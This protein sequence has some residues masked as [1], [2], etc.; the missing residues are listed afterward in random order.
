MS[1]THAVSGA[2]T[3]NW[4]ARTLGATRFS[5]RRRTTGYDGQVAEHPAAPPT[6]TSGPGHVTARRTSHWIRDELT[7]RADI[8]RA[9]AALL[10]P[11]RAPLDRGAVLEHIE[12][13]AATLHSLGIGAGHR[14]ATIL[15]P[16]PEAAL[17]VLGVA[18]VSA[19]A[20]LDPR[21]PPPEVARMLADVRT[22]AVILPAGA[23]REPARAQGCAVI[24]LEARPSRGAG[25]HAL[26]VRERGTP[27][28]PAPGEAALLLRTSGTT[29]RPKWVALR[30]D[31]LVASARH[32]EAAL[33][34]SRDDRCLNLMPLFHINGLVMTLAT[35]LTGGSIAC[36]PGF[37]ADRFAG[38]LAALTPTWING[39]PTMLRAMARLARGAP[40][41]GAERLR[42]IR[43][44]SAPLAPALMAE[45]EH[46]FGVPVIETY[47]HTETATLVTANPLS[48]GRR[49]PGSVGV[50][51]A[52][53]AMVVDDAGAPVPAGTIGEVVV[54]GPNVI[55][56]YEDDADAAAFRDGWLRTGDLGR[57]DEDGYLFL[58]GR[59]K[60]MINRGG[61]KIAPREVDEA[62]AGHPAVAAAA[63]FPVPH[64]TLGED[65]AAA[66]VLVP[67]AH[68]SPDELQAFVATQLA[69]FK[70]PRRVAVVDRLPQG[71]TGKVDRA[72][73][74]RHA[75]AAPERSRVP[76]RTAQ[77][78]AVAAI[79]CEALGLGAVGVDEDFFTLGGDSILA[80]QV[81]ARIH[82][83]TG[84]ELPSHALFEAPTVARLSGLLEG[85][86]AADR[87]RPEPRLRARELAEA[88]LSFAQEGLWFLDQLHPGRTD[89]NVAQAWRLRGPLDTSALGRSLQ[90]VV[91]R[92][93]ALRTV[94]LAR[95]GRPVQR[96]LP[97]LRLELPVIDLTGRAADRRLDEARR[98]ARAQAREPFALDRGPLVRGALLRMDDADHVLILTIHHIVFD[99][100]SRGVLCRELSAAYAALVAGRDPG[101]PPLTRQFAD[102]AVDARERLD[103]D[104][105]ARHLAYWRERMGRPF[106]GLTLPTDRPRGD[107][108]SFE[109]A[110]ETFRVPA[111]V[112]A[113]VRGLSRAEGATPFMTLLAAFKALL[114]RC[115][116]QGDIVVGTPGANR[117]SPGAQALIGFFVNTLALRTDL[118][119]NPSFR[120]VLR[121]VRETVVGAYAHQGLP[122]DRLVEAI[123][124]ARRAA[125]TPLLQAL[126][127]L[128][129]L[130]TRELA[131]PG[132]EVER[133]PVDTGA[134]RFELDL[135]L[136][137]TSR[138]L[139]GEL[140]WDVSLF[141]RATA[142][143]IVDHFQRLLE[144][145]VADP[146]RSIGAAPLLGEAEAQQRWAAGRGPQAEYPAARLV[147]Q[148]IEAQAARTPRALAVVLDDDAV[149]YAELNARA[150]RLA[151]ALR[152]RGVAPGMAVGVLLERSP[153]LLVGLLG[154]LKAGGAFVALDPA[155]P[156][157]RLRRMLDVAGATILVTRSAL[158]DLIVG[159]EAIVDLDDAQGTGE[160]ENP[161]PVVEPEAAA[162]I[163]FTSGSTGQP[164]GI[165]V[166]HRGVVNYLG[167]L[168]RTFALGPEDVCLQVASVSFDA[169]MREL[170]GPLM[171]GG[172]VALLRPDE[173]GDPA[174]M[175]ARMD[176][177]RV[178]AL[179]ALVPT[180]L[181]VLTTGAEARG[182]PAAALRLALVSGEPLAAP[183]C[184][185]A[186]RHLG[187]R[188]LLVNQYG[189][190]ETTMT[191][192]YQVVDLAQDAAG[193]IPIGRAI[194][195]VELH[196]LDEGMRPVPVGYPG[197]IFIGGDGLAMGY[198]A[199]AARTA[200]R[201]VPHPG[202]ASGARLYR[203]GD[204]GR[205]RDDGRLEYL[206][207]LDGRL[208]VRGVLGEPAEIEG[209]LT[210]HPDVREAAVALRP[211]P[212]GEDVLVAYV[213]TRWRVE[214]TVLRR[215]LAA[216]L[217]AA[218]VPSAFVSMDTLPLLPNRKVDRAALPPPASV[219]LATGEAYEEPRTPLERLVADV[220]AE[221][222]GVRNVGRRDGFFDLG[223]HSLL[224]ARIAGQLREH[225]GVDIPL[226]LFFETPD[227]AGFAAVLG[228]R[229]R[230]DAAAPGAPP[231]AG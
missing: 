100:W 8:D 182:R 53:T 87:R 181:R 140:T 199:D 178:T 112:E 214:P 159:L 28:D 119:G 9:T 204:R 153:E 94:F 49:K 30:A 68:V 43:S 179:L 99:G 165:A 192:S 205:V 71:P 129:N 186:R 193:P 40:P 105:H 175:L 46:L 122:F 51:V 222:L 160:V 223:G 166:T 18:G 90:L 117:D 3:A 137:E 59:V 224:A 203:T 195:N 66:V 191:A 150:N 67:G 41:A 104:E 133:E 65:V 149:T 111:K 187:P 229:I 77:E 35:L 75:R 126:F 157:T 139:E 69:D 13:L 92:H 183:D 16:G 168:V 58:T 131:L 45:I 101:L 216:V 95:A 80:T 39:T 96:I 196:V 200:E 31:H 211:G 169:S 27:R 15:P 226:R 142:R 213:V 156:A 125:G 116:G 209:A 184:A 57:F 231:A 132:L 120:E 144:V 174:A 228:N 50:V 171:V 6:T 108:P 48:P 74:S 11:G 190:S 173:V 177:C 70:V 20:P 88:P 63:A 47:G 158:R 114:V 218:L 84:I 208:K 110:L 180:V 136:T 37:D 154:V 38:W 194:P 21:L 89:Y 24:E 197:E 17:A 145:V 118:S 138:G 14:V 176:R 22:S 128:D 97:A 172:V 170:F 32:A 185:A 83:T 61:E 109:G 55:E 19:C 210:E 4:R 123:R 198:V 155:Y 103:E 115:T 215:H 134:A 72:A 147:H 62:L 161:E 1:V 106:A 130:R 219:D 5:P 207:R 107:G 163:T 227:L 127:A 201:F 143:R 86:R 151:H 162:Y 56:A 82:E 33:A 64:P 78:T 225:L 34:L 2:G 25:A 217:P 81:L 60:E 12:A 188:A 73:L 202:G 42:L 36:V 79:W 85:A 44:A 206:G 29:G 54:R 121:R 230:G 124:P 76:P 23:A 189:P 152:R 91:D 135:A 102:H 98:R 113:A 52:G 221:C 146:D 212:A 141:D 167:Y 164:K 148:L 220:W 10:A 26:H 7:R 93:E